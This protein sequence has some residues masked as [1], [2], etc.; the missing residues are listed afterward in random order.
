[1][2]FVCLHALINCCVRD[3][4]HPF[5]NDPEDNEADELLSFDPAIDEK[6]T[7]R[8]LDLLRFRSRASPREKAEAGADD[9]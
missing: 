6:Q 8:E 1:M 5:K 7:N 3:A 2:N 4:L 9:L